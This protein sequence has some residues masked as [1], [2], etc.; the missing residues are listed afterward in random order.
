MYRVVFTNRAIKKTLKRWKKT[1][2]CGLPENLST[3]KSEVIG[4]G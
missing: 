1:L 3:L 2:N 4:L